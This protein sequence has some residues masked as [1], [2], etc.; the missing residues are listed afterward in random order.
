MNSKFLLIIASTFLLASCQKEPNY[1]SWLGKW[2]GVEGTYLNLSQ[3]GE[4]Y[5][6]TI[7]DLDGP[8]DFKGEAGRGGISFIRNG[9]TETL[10]TGNGEATGMKWLS[11][12]KDCL[13]VRSG[14]GFCRD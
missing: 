14:E 8:K 7:S 6:V 5:K 1:Q 4:A 13:I 11:G 3:D 9:Q 2:T 10:H 12:K